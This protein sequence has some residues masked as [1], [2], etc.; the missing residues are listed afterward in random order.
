MPPDLAD[1]I[2]RAAYRREL[3]AIARPIRAAGIAFALLGVVLVLI[4]QSAWPAMPRAIPIAAVALGLV[5][6][7]GAIVLRTRYHQARMR[8]EGG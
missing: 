6:M 2:A 4:K 1:P 8:G 3:R 7:L 5:N